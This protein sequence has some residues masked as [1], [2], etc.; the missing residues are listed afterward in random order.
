MKK[1]WSLKFVL[2]IFVMIWLLSACNLPGKELPAPANQG[3][4]D[5]ST[6]VP[7]TATEELEE[8][9][10]SATPNVLVMESPDPATVAYDFVTEVCS[11]EWTTNATS[12]PCPGNL[13]DAEG[14]YITPADHTVI[15]GM[16][17]VEAPL[18]IG[19]P[20][21]GYPAGLGLFG[22]YPPF[23]V[24]PG[25]TFRAVIACQGDADCDLEFALEYF[26]AQGD[27]HG[28]AYRWYHKAGDGPQ[29]IE[30]DLD[31]L[32]GQT[33]ELMLVLRSKVLD[34][35]WGVWIQ[36]YIKRDPNA[37]PLPT[38]ENPPTPSLNPEDKTPGVISGMVDMSSAPPYLNDPMIGKSSP[39]AV[40]FF[41]LSDGTYWW[42]HTSLTGHP[43]YQMTITPGEYQVVA[44]A[45][46]VGD[47]PYV[48]A[49]YTGQNPSCGKNLKTVTM[50][51]N[52]RLENI[53]IADWNWTCGGTAYRPPKPSGV[54]LP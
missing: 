14:G 39:V 48:T 12:R 25:D 2:S 44:Y 16:V 13:E 29:Q 32:A 46:G 41:N 10:P 3:D 33:V 37:K 34:G 23:T 30:A 54:P 35:Q 18:L 42:I 20:G 1:P 40:V 5:Q 22:K 9:T 43:Y 6:D 8:P 11:A 31:A 26:D 51:P 36:P 24:Y 27:Y 45:H 4:L 49:G 7:P 15:E 47:I 52:G 53:V 28:S 17:S 38:A 21:N 19:L 50:G